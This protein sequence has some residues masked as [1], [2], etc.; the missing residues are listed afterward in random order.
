MSPL[1]ALFATALLSSSFVISGCGQ[2]PV[3]DAIASALDDDGEE[4]V[5]EPEDAKAD[6]AGAS[7][8]LQFEGSCSFLRNCSA[9]SHTRVTFGCDSTYT[10]GDNKLWVA[11]P[12][13]AHACD[14]T[15]KICRGGSCI[16]AKVVDTSCCG[17]WEASY[18][19]LNALGLPAASNA[20]QCTGSG[21]GT[22]TIYR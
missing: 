10:C 20:S 8:R 15:V 22:V 21:G 12:R 18:G 1:S 11:A 6:G 3:D 16:R 7:V 19:V 9:Y 2:E 17:H 13:A 4:V 5:F 14:E